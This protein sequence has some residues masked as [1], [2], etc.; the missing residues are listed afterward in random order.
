MDGT[1]KS[2]KVIIKEHQAILELTKKVDKIFNVI[3]QTQLGFNNITI[4]LAGYAFI[5]VSH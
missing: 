5:L 2:L 3:G 4:G 1:T